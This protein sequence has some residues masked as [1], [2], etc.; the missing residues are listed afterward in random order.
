[1]HTNLGN[2]HYP[3]FGDKEAVK[4]RDLSGPG[5]I[6]RKK[7]NQNLPGDYVRHCKG[8]GGIAPQSVES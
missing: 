6:A 1:M 3:H 8:F 2:R 4:P 5:Y 7:S